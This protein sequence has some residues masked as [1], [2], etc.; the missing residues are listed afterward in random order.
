MTTVTTIKPYREVIDLPDGTAKLRLNLHKGQQKVWVSK[1]R[2]PVLLA[3]TQ[4]GKTC[5]Q[6]D[7]LYREITEQGEGDYIVGSAT[8]PLLGLKVLPEFQTLY[9]DLLKWGEYKDDRMGNRIIQAIRV[10]AHGTVK[11]IDKSRIIFFSATNPESMESATAKAA[12]LDEAGQKQFRHA[13]WEAVQRRLAINRGRC[14]FGTTLYS[15]GWLKTEVYDRA[16]AGDNDF[17][18]IHGDSIDNPVFPPEEY[19]RQKS[20][21]PSWKF[22]MF[23]RGRYSRPVGLVFD[24]FNEVDDVIDRFEIPKNWLIYVGHDF[25]SANPAAMFYAQDPGT[26]QFYAFAE[27]LPGPGQSV[28]DHVQ[29]FKKITEGYHVITRAGGNWTTEEEIR[30]AYTA[31]GWHIQKPKWKDPQKQ[32]EIVYGMNKLHKIKVFRD[33]RHYLDQKTSFSYE[34]DE[35]YQPTDKYDNETVMHLL[36]AERYIIGGFTPETVLHRGSNKIPAVDYLKPR[37]ETNILELFRRG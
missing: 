25:G 11:V 28:Y 29:E 32:Y 36:A 18:I 34:L 22:D 5:L 30:Q 3:G 33:L 14:L 24:C 35:K 15:L 16:M 37:R 20:I 4:F 21:L 26:G 13:T 1:A 10:I 7:W 8:F 6:P 17:E 9:C 2:F 27:Y 19:Y 12:V 23:Y 31:Q